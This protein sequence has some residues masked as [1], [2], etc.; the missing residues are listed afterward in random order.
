MCEIFECVEKDSEKVV[1]KKGRKK[2]STQPY[3]Y[4]DSGNNKGKSVRQN[5]VSKIMPFKA[6][7]D[8]CTQNSTHWTQKV[9]T[10]YIRTVACGGGGIED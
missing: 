6:I 5:E 4:L 8:S 10:R 7:K 1:L 9:V 2:V 3:G